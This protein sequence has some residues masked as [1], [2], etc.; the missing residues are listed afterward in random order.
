MKALFTPH[1]PQPIGPYSQAIDCGDVVFCSGAIATIPETGK[2]LE[3]DARAQTEQVLKNLG[4]VLKAGGL[5]YA[6][7]VKTTIFLTDMNDFP[8]VNAAYVSAFADTKPARSTVGV[9][10]LPLGAKVEIDAVAIRSSG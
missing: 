5:S 6:Q 9:A 8:E 1:A 7:V 4:E 3:G 2:L 10:S